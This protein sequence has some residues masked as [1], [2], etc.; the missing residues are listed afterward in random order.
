VA[1]M[2][3][4]AFAQEALFKSFLQELSLAA[5]EYISLLFKT[6]KSCSLTL[7]FSSLSSA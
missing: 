7:A 3:F 2:N 4:D 5:G 6:S 1:E